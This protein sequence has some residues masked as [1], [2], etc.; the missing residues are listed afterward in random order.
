MLW[1]EKTLYCN[2]YNVCPLI[3]VLVHPCKHQVINYNFKGA[4]INTLN[5]NS[6]ETVNTLNPN[7]SQTVNTPNLNSN[8]SVN[9]LKTN[10]SQTFNHIEQIAIE[11]LKVLCTNTKLNQSV[12]KM[13]GIAFINCTAL[14]CNEQRIIQTI[15]DVLQ[16][17]DS[18]SNLNL[19]L[20][21]D[22]SN[23]LVMEDSTSNLNLT[24]KK[25]DSNC[26]VIP[27]EIPIHNMTCLKI[28]LAA[29]IIEQ[30]WWH[31]ERYSGVITVILSR[32]SG[33]CCNK[34]LH[35]MTFALQTIKSCLDHSLKVDEFLIEENLLSLIFHVVLGNWENYIPSVMEHN[36]ILFESF[37]KVLKKKD[38]GEMNRERMWHFLANVSCT[39]KS[40]YYMMATCF[41]ADFYY[42]N[43]FTECWFINNMAYSLSR[44]YLVTAGAY[45]HKVLTKNIF[46][47]DKWKQIFLDKVMELVCHS[48]IYIRQN[49]SNYWLP[50]AIKYYPNLIQ[51]LYDRTLSMY[52]RVLTHCATT[53][54]MYCKNRSMDQVQRYLH[55]VVLIVKLERAAKFTDV[56]YKAVKDGMQCSNEMI[57]G[58]AF[59]CC[60]SF[61]GVKCHVPMSRSNP[62]TLDCQTFED[63]FEFLVENINCD[64]SNLRQTI[65]KVFKN[66][67][68]NT[69]G[70]IHK[71][72]V[73]ID[74]VVR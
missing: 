12:L 1:N 15:G 70:Q 46:T 5:P 39:L 34:F 26:S 32:L 14:L 68:R 65:Y 22:D 55:S 3:F 73:P 4:F 42:E 38:V 19:T 16:M 44:S 10:S 28:V 59:L 8:K 67:V 51:T 52:N 60:Q 17:D 54:S 45:L 49:V 36:L 30:N 29:A 62:H 47:E 63:I 21:G 64:D 37:I 41:L 56:T 33:Y 50:V 66:Y 27:T 23:D 69:E 11:L 58:D 24:L 48:D 7:S 25:D 6:S 72:V 35:E 9:T 18:T 20:K 53:E 61:N 13:V 40:K 2:I 31:I 43:L 57:R 74:L 71:C